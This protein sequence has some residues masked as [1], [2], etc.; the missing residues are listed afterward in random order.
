MSILGL[1]VRARPRDLPALRRRLAA[2][3]QVDVADNPD[4]DGPDGRLVVVVEDG[5]ER[6]AAATMAEIA[7]WPQ[8]LS[9]SLVYEDAGPDAPAPGEAPNAFGAWRGR[10]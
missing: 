5:A 4:E 8:V 6:S 7:V 3:P 2:L 1:I 10:P 9:T